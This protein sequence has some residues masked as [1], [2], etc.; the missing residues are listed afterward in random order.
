MNLQDIH[1]FVDEDS[2]LDEDFLARLKQ[3]VL[4]VL[5][6]ENS[7]LPVN[8]ILTDD[9]E[10]RSLNRDYRNKD[11][12]TDVLS[13]PWDADGDPDDLDPDE[14]LL[15]ELYIAVPQV[16][17]QAPRF[18]TTFFEEMERVT[19]HG[20]L[21]LLG[22]DH[23]KPGERAIMRAREEYHLGR[24]PYRDEKEQ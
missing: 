20:L 8:I 11:K 24:S 13:F 4:R 9:A 12:T 17:R 18:G 1:L 14:K 15:G 3:V 6:T 23:M 21:H 7:S 2:T 10:V 16:E 5:Q 19:V 22:H